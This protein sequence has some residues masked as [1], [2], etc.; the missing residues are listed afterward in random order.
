MGEEELAKLKSELDASN[1]THESTLA[2]LRQKHN[3]TIA[4]M[5]DQIDQLNKQKAKVEEMQRALHEA[6][7]SKRKLM[8]EQCDLTH[9]LEEA[10]R[11]LHQLSKDKTSLTTQ[12]DDSK[13]LADAET[14]ERINLL[15]KMRNLEHELEVMKEHLDEEC[16]AKQE[17]ARQ[18]SKAFADIQLWKTRY[19]TEGVAR[20]E[21]IERDKTKV[22]AR[23]SEGED[24]ISSLQEKISILEKSKV[25]LSTELDDLTSECERH[26]TTATNPLHHH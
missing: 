18:L 14:R 26:T 16:E 2:T 15:G 6:D 12:L 9:H 17:I 11:T 25:R 13:R 3:T 20:I 1:I 22:G 10:E 24:T 4:E 21:E 7:G 23:L 8:V 19:E 5:G